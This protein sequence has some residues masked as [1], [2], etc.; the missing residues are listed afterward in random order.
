MISLQADLTFSSGN[1]GRTIPGKNYSCMAPGMGQ[2]MLFIKMINLVLSMPI[3]V[4]NHLGPVRGTQ[5][6]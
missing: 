6:L 5:T 3:S 4:L 1:T 2:T